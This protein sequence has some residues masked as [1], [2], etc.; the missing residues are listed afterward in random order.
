[1]SELLNMYIGRRRRVAQHGWARE[2]RCPANTQP[3]LLAAN[4]A[5][6]LPRVRALSTARRTQ[7]ITTSE[8][9]R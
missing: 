9:T 6:P 1:M 5:A 4:G 8:E 7:R 2:I 3:V